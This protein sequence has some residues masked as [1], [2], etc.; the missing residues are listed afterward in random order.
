[1]TIDSAEGKNPPKI[2][3]KERVNLPLLTKCGAVPGN[4]INDKKNDK[5]LISTI[6]W[7]SVVLTTVTLRPALVRHSFGTQ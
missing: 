6:R 3:W 5:V 1:M 2:D 7:T 4:H